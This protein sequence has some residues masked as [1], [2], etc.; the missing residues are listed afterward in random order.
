MSVTSG[1]ISQTSVS[2]T[3]A[4]LAATAA[5]G[6]TGTATYQWYRSTT[7][8]FTPGAGNIIAGATNA[9]A[10]SDTGLI[11][12]T[13][14]YYKL[15]TVDEAPSTDT[16]NQLTVVTTAVVF[17]PN[18]FN[19]I[20]I[21]GQMDMRINPNVMSAQI[22][23]S[24][25]TTLY[26]GTAVKM[27]DSAD[28]IPKVVKCTADADEV[29]GFII[30]DVKS[31]SFVALD[32]VEIALAGSV[33]YLM[34]TGTITRGGKVVSDVSTVGGFDAA[35]GSGGEDIIGWALDKPTAGNPGRVM[36][37]TPSFLKDA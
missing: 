22:D 17:S 19:Q 2:D 24:E 35:S 8:G 10:L 33:M 16:S 29:L 23:S 28:G 13:T 27:Y 9:T 5:T 18:Q 7:T 21:V 6:V 34:P 30:Y 15:V 20:P 1:A 36:L 25:S 4:V 31:Q 32:R 3:S 26:A 12:N 14:Y 11:P 37:T